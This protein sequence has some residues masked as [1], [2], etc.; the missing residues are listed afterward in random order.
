MFK[1]QV[2]IQK[3]K[4]LANRQIERYGHHLIRMIHLRQTKGSMST[5]L[6]EQYATVMRM[7]HPK[8]LV[9]THMELFG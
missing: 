4:H 7:R 5:R 2:Y 3:W 6:M 8:E 1:D 9:E